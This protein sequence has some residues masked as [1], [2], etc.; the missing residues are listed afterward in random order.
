MLESV[1]S[2]NGANTEESFQSV[3]N[4]LIESHYLISSSFLRNTTIN[5]PQC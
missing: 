4:D 3:F 2:I 5:Y 1:A